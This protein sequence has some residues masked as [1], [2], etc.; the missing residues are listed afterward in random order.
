MDIQAYFNDIRTVIAVDLDQARR[1]IDA[2]VA[3]L[4]DPVLFEALLLRAARR[5]CQVRLAF[6]DDAINRQSGLN[7]ER[8]R[9]A[10]GEV[11]WIPVAQGGQGSLHHKF[12]VIDGDGKSDSRSA[13]A[14][15]LPASPR[16]RRRTATPRL[17]KA[18]PGWA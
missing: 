1:S 12:Y 18:A 8:L 17:R 13:T 9:A 15:P 4:T 5:G 6:L 7:L 11:F 2:A 3:W 10:G 16:H 14:A